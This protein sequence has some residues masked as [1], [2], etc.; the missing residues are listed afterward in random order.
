MKD[1]VHNKPHWRYCLRKSLQYYRTNLGDIHL[2]AT[3]FLYQNRYK[4][5]VIYE[6][7]Y[8]KKDTIPG[9]TS[10]K[11]QNSSIT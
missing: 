10:I 8:P 3:N 6:K 11:F 2:E 5:A 7:R 4:S 9:K 1:N